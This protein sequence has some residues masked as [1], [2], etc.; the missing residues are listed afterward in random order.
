[1]LFR[2]VNIHLELHVESKP[3]L[4][5]SW[6][7]FLAI[8]PHPWSPSL[9]QILGEQ[10]SESERQLFERTIRPVVESG[11]S[12]DTVFIAYLTAERPA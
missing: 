5:T 7:V 8:S 11:K 2:S 4:I 10:F 3:S 6:E 9:G 1:M 12:V